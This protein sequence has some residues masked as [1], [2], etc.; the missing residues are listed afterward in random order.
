[1]KCEDCDELE[2]EWTPTDRG[3]LKGWHCRLDKDEEECGD[4]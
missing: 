2:Q 4:E 1:M 3:T